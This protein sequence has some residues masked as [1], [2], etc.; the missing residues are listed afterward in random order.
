MCAGTTPGVAVMDDEKQAA[1]PDG[2]AAE[3]DASGV[4]MDLLAEHVPLTLLADLA[5]AEPRSEAIL[6]AE[7]L[8]E[9]AW[10]EGEDEGAAPAPAAGLPAEDDVPADPDAAAEP[11]PA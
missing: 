2:R 11:H 8:P 4:V 3:G 7:G 1:E 10:W 6:V 9:D 5:V